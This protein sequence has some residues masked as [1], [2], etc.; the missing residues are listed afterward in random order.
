[1]KLFYFGES[2]A[3]DEVFSLKIED[4]DFQNKVI[5]YQSHKSIYPLHV[6]HDLRELI[7]ERTSG[8]VFKNRRGDRIDHTGPY[9]NLKRVISELNLDPKLSFRDLSQER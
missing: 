9:R 3:R 4:I 5:A 2:P 7:G 1:M 8:F 6:F